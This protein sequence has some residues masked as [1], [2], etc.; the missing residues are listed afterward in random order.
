M[1]K[2]LSLKTAFENLQSGNVIEA[3]EIFVGL[4]QDPKT[5]KILESLS[6]DSEQDT[7]ENP[8]NQHVIGPQVLPSSIHN[9]P[10]T[11]VELIQTQESKQVNPVSPAGD[12]FDHD[13]AQDFYEDLYDFD[14]DVQK[15]VRLSSDP[16]GAV[17]HISNHSL[18]SD[19]GFDEQI[20]LPMITE[21]R[22]GQDWSL[23]EDEEEDEE[24]EDEDEDNDS[25]D[26]GDEDTEEENE[27]DQAEQEQESD[28]D[29]QEMS[30]ED[31]DK[32]MK[33]L[34]K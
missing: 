25:M 28:E 18:E 22:I 16:S 23:H 21:E 34:M 1:T 29:D 12:F 27:E 14:V 4:V 24:D 17:L 9:K 20:P 11:L 8:S 13:P 15:M 6:Q 32:Q 7:E 19:D 26:D 2:R 31:V 30:D 5:T 10:K 33:D 3:A